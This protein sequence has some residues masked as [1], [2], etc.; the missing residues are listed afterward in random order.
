MACVKG[1]ENGFEHFQLPEPTLQDFDL[2]MKCD[3]LPADS[4]RGPA[5][6]VHVSLFQVST[7]RDLGSLHYIRTRSFL[8]GKDSPTGRDRSATL[9]AIRTVLPLHIAQLVQDPLGFRRNE[10]FPV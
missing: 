5:V 8:G 7:E 4:S 9:D 1:H 6:L 3:L 2:G 10:P